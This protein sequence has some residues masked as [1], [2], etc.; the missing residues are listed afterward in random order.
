M[1]DKKLTFKV[2]GKKPRW[3][4]VEVENANCPECG[5]LMVVVLDADKLL[6]G[7]CLGCRKYFL[8]Q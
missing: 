7:I 5:K 3:V 1:T 2:Q 8:G 6:Y 4:E